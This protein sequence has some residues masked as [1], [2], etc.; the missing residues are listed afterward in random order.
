VAIPL[1][2]L[3]EP[4]Q[5]TF[6]VLGAPGF[7]VAL[8]LL[9]LHEPP[10]QQEPAQALP[11]EASAGNFPQLLVRRWRFFV[12]VYAALG[13]SVFAGFGGAAWMATVAIRRY[14]LTPAYVGLVGG[15]I[16][17]AMAT[18]AP[19]AVGVLSDWAASRQPGT[20]RLSLI[21]VLFVAQIPLICGWAFLPVPF[22]LFLVFSVLNGAIGS[23]LPSTAYIILQEA[24]PNHMRAQAV[25]V[26]QVLSNFLGMGLGALVMALVTEDVFHDDMKIGD[27]VASVS[28]VCTVLGLLSILAAIRYMRSIAARD[29]DG[30]VPASQPA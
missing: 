25:A 7:L 29:I 6:I 12:P 4:W 19:Y 8:L 15:T 30:G 5:V 11:A 21:A 10:R 23:G 14:A 24:V 16:T 2:G 26:F 13:F 3:A 1:L 18:V 20:G 27:A 17:L 22:W 9:M 28:L